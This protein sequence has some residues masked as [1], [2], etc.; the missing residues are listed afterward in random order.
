MRHTVHSDGN[1]GRRGILN[2]DMVELGGKELDKIVGG[3]DPVRL[4]GRIGDDCTCGYCGL[5]FA[6]SREVLTH[7]L[8]VHLGE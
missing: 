6:N 8:K 2:E 4:T 7:L 1:D 3:V 5:Q